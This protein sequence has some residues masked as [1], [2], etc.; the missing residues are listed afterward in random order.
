MDSIITLISG[1]LGAVIGYVATN[2]NPAGAAWGWAI[3][4]A[5]GGVAAGI[6][7]P[8]DSVHNKGPRMDDLS[9]QTSTYG[10][11]IPKI[12]GTMRVA[13]NIFWAQDIDEDRKIRHLDGDAEFWEYNYYATFAL[14]LCEGPIAGIRKIYLDGKLFAD[15]SDTE[16]V[17]TSEVITQQ[18]GD[19]F[20]VYNGTE[21]QTVDPTI[22]GAIAY[23]G[24][25]YI[26]FKDLP[27][28][29]YSNRI[30]QVTCEV[31]ADGFVSSGTFLEDDCSGVI[32]ITA[33]WNDWLHAQ[34]NPV[35]YNSGSLRI[36]NE[37]GSH[38]ATYGKACATL[39]PQS[40]GGLFELDFSYW[41]NN[42]WY[43]DT[44][45]DAEAEFAM[46]PGS[47]VCCTLSTCYRQ[48][49]ENGYGANSKLAFNLRTVT[50][51]KITVRQRING[52]FTTLFDEN[53]TYHT[54]EFHP[55][56]I[57]I[58]ATNCWFEI[59]DRWSGVS[60][61]PIA[62]GSETQIG[63][64]T[65]FSPTLM[66]YLTAASNQVNF[67][68]HFHN[69]STARYF[70][71]DNIVFKHGSSTKID[72]QA[73]TQTNTHRGLTITNEGH[74]ISC[75]TQTKLI[76]LH[77][78]TSSTV[79]SQFVC[80]NPLG[81]A[82][83]PVALCT[84]NGDLYV[85]FNEVVSGLDRPFVSCHVGYTAATRWISEATGMGVDMAAG[86][87][88][89]YGNVLYLA[90]TTDNKICRFTEWQEGDLSSVFASSNGLGNSNGGANIYGITFDEAGN[91]YQSNNGDEKVFKT[92]SFGALQDTLDFSGLWEANS[93]GDIHYN[94]GTG[95]LWIARITTH[96]FVAVDGEEFTETPLE[97]PKVISLAPALS[98][99]VEDIC[100]ESGL[101]AGEI[102]VSGISGT[103]VD[104]YVR[105]QCMSGKR[106]LEP[107]MGAFVFDCA[108]YDHKLNFNLRGG[109][110]Q[111]SIPSDEIGA[112]E[113]DPGKSAG[114]L[115]IINENQLKFPREYNLQFISPSEDYE[116]GLQRSVR[117]TVGSKTVLKAEFPIAM[118]H[119]NAKRQSE[120][121]HAIMWTER[122]KYKFAT[123]WKYLYL[124]PADVIT[125]A[126][127]KMRI[128]SMNIKDNLLEIEGPAEE[129][130]D[131]V[132][133]SVADDPIGSGGQV[134]DLE[135]PTVSELLDI[136]I[137]SDTDNNAGF[138]IAMH[139]YGSSAWNG[140]R[141]LV[142]GG[143]GFVESMIL[144]SESKMGFATNTLAQQTI[145]PGTFDDVNT[146]N[147]MLDSTNWSLTNDSEINVLNGA[148]WAALG[149]HGRW[150]IIGFTTV[151]IQG[152]GSYTLSGLLRGIR[153]TEWAGA[154]HAA[155][156]RFVILTRSSIGRYI[157]SDSIIDVTQSYKMISVG[158]NPDFYS[159]INFTN[160]AESLH[161][162][163]PSDI[164]ASRDGSNN[165]TLTWKRR[166][167]V[168]GEW[169][170]YQ[171]VPIGEASEEYEIDIMD[172]ATVKRAVTGLSSATYYYSIDDQN[173]DWLGPKN[174]VTVRVYQVSA[175]VGRG[176]TNEISV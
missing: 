39:F 143:S 145:Y 22:G 146:V 123:S 107:L 28:A 149:I 18:R 80:P 66:E 60:N 19:Y 151:A 137:I 176:H 49:E 120:I 85:A 125:V 168:G 102:N 75:D 26:V 112:Y 43:N 77:S 3:G 110:S 58:D 94:K 95:I 158:A 152:N 130:A 23:R 166:T 96:S 47:P 45:T 129:Q 118:T 165:I 101:T 63:A 175:T 133:N 17:G 111:V 140:G 32:P 4:S 173:D 76:S 74:L 156:D 35:Y 27:L 50:S 144:T 48:V 46:T 139:G 116:P 163:A 44:L 161:P 30:P 53:I 61:V 174:P 170:D 25:A 169:A 91:M 10:V 73:P 103:T 29:N 113:F 154:L 119:T 124:A 126:N 147:I 109:S 71:V 54:N 99:I 159:G 67:T 84:Y 51:G 37:S 157:H 141:V 5:V 115:E 2:F 132:S 42:D 135:P 55:L 12:Y 24:L 13:G 92:N 121:L 65:S 148:N 87:I 134:I 68:Y 127:H 86:G 97:V 117:R 131:Y 93:V 82:A 171:D 1:A 142:D 33:K 167:R 40:A 162:Y 15:M 128:G 57:K 136:N 21:D 70:R 155:Q 89:I 52:V 7:I 88:A 72:L 69:Y 9:V 62:E 122:V 78:G 64:R 38:S 90:N 14:G 83:T 8:P 114:T 11:D 108:E 59:Y 98:D 20:L 31:V 41:Q 150:E 6:L 160:H 34:Y 36:D 138:Y 104:G 106:A 100:L 105:A 172:G 79:V 16:L 153:G 81:T 56:R 164:K